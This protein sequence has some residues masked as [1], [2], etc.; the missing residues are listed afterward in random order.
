MSDRELSLKTIFLFWL[1]L[2][3]TWLMMAA[4][5]PFLAAVIARL[6]EPKFNLAAYGVAFSLGIFIEA[7]II[8][9][10]S[11]STA[12]VKDWSSYLRLRNFTNFLNA[13]LTF[14]ILL[15][16][17]PPVFQVVAVRLIGLP[18]EVVRLTQQ[19]VI[20]LIPWPGVIGYRRFYQGVLIRYRLTRRVA[21]GTVIRLTTMATTAFLVSRFTGLPGASVGA[22][23][24][25]AGVTAE[26]V[27]SRL[28]VHSL[29]RRLKAEGESIPA[30]APLSYRYITRFYY[31]LALTSVLALGVQPLVTFFLGHSR[32]PIESLAVGPVI[33]SFV[34]IFRS[35]G[36]SFQEVAIA[37]LGEKNEHLG[38]IRKFALI[39]GG[40]VQLA[41]LL[42][43]FSPF[44]YVWFHDI[45][46]LSIELARFSLLPTRILVLIP[47]LTLLLSFQRA[48][49]VNNQRTKPITTATL[50]EVGAIVL[51]LLVTLRGFDLVGIVGAALALMIGRVLAVTYL[52]VPVRVVRSL[53]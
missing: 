10:M 43:A 30:A 49:L 42:V 22:L 3:S 40:G 48:Y 51:V 24:L 15:V 8:M 34:F 50:L 31:P 53:R 45:S 12:L 19:A 13:V 39:L 32:M 1:P 11:A 26:A 47:P 38:Q 23:S 21:Y 6:A 36:L 2:A 4:E 5:G 29:L 37:L 25:S 16:C 7:P 28:M 17:L 20:F 18:A 14:L 35:I 46:G 44:A 52:A 27:A 9:I 33:N 41:F